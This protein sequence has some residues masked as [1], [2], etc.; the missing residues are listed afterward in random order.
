MTKKIKAIQKM[1]SQAPKLLART[2][3]KE[4]NENGF[5][6]SQI[7]QFTAEL[8]SCVTENNKCNGSAG[9]NGKNGKAPGKHLTSELVE[10][11]N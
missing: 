2:L 7:I 11:G 9:S 3:F 8:I 10:C 5:S 1:S 4:L 6:D